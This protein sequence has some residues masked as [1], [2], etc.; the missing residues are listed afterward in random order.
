MT[1]PSARAQLNVVTLMFTFS[2]MNYF[3][4][5]IMSI[6][7]PDIM[8]EFGLVPTQMGVVYSAFLLAYALFMMP[9]GQLVDWLGPRWSLT[10]MG[11]GAA[12]FTG[13]TAWGGKPG[14][15]SWIGVLPALAGIRFLMGICT[16]PLYPACGRMCANWIAPVYLGRVQGVIIGG[17]SLGGAVAPILFVT[18]MGRLGWRMSFVAAA[19]ATAVLALVW[20]LSVTD[21][22]GAMSVKHVPPAWRLLLKNRNL[23]LLTAAYAALGYFSYIF[24]YWIYFYFGEIRHMGYEQSARFTTL[25]FIVNGLMIPVGGWLSDTLTRRHGQRF[26]RRAVPI[27]GLTVSAILLL[28]GIAATGTWTTVSLF[29][30]SMGFAS[31]CEGPFWAMTIALG[32]EHAGAACSILNTGSNLAGFAAPVLTPYIASYLGWSWGL[33]F[34]CVVILLGAVACWRVR[35]P[36]MASGLTEPPHDNIV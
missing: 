17:S 24:Y 14:L 1:Q 7:G 32:G 29:A 25:V 26:G 12:L 15:G 22:P 33:N 35:L 8:K 9:G 11:F 23:L 19:L 13:L 20:S 28:A 3:D 21:R 16:S 36:P 31:F 18:L 2:M 27:A 4:R 6:A 34:G 5:T 30:F 10:L